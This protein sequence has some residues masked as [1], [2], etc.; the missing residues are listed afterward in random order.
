VTK[1]VVQR[2]KRDP[3]PERKPPVRDDNQFELFGIE[4]AKKI[5]DD[6]FLTATNTVVIREEPYK[7]VKQFVLDR[8]AVREGKRGNYLLVG[9]DTEYQPL[10]DSFTTQDVKDKTARYEVL[11][12]QFHAIQID[13]SSWSGIAVPDQG[14]RLTF[15]QFLIYALAAGAEQ[16]EVIPQ[17]IVLVGHY[18]RADVPAFDDRDQIYDRVKNVRNSLITQAVPITVKVSFGDDPADDLDIK[19]YLRDTM[20]LAPAGRKSLASLG[21]RSARTK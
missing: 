8:S 16:G 2:L 6:V 21:G 7:P 13:G 3:T 17:N 20:L 14:R 10:Q 15:A 11:S 4:K 18:N 19:V 9:F 5:D 12:Y 1:S